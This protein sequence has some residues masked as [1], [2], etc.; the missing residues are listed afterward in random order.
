MLGFVI[1]YFR[2]MTIFLSI[3]HVDCD[4]IEANGTVLFRSLFC[5]ER[6]RSVFTKTWVQSRDIFWYFTMV[7]FS[8]VLKALYNPGCVNWT[9][10]FMKWTWTVISSASLNIQPHT[11]VLPAAKGFRPE[12]IESS[13]FINI[14]SIKNMPSLW[15][16][17][18]LSLL[19]LISTKCL[20]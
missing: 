9:I 6:S 5:L 10:I 2:E 16:T 4:D 12:C 14:F 13:C 7:L 17:F 20:H 8:M 11:G 18:I 19:T 15:K 3:D 1:H